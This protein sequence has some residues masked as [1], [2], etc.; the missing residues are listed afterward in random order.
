MLRRFI[1]RELQNEYDNV[2]SFH[3]PPTVVRMTLI[4]IPVWKYTL[5]PP[6]TTEKGA[7]YDEESDVAIAM[8]GKHSCTMCCARAVNNLVQY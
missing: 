8:F 5:C 7:S 2:T 3:A 1:L 6:F 4:V